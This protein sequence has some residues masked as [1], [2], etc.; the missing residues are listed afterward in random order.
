ME[1]LIPRFALQGYPRSRKDCNSASQNLAVQNKVERFTQ[2]RAGDIRINQQQ[3]NYDGV[4]VGVNRP[5]L[6][7]SPDRQ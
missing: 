7:Y 3:V 4:R 2:L 6:Q 1:L 5:D